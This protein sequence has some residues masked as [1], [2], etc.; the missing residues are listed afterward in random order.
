[1]PR[2]CTIC[3]HPKRK[4]IDRALANGEALRVI[5]ARYGT[6]PQTL[7]RHKRK[8]VAPALE[9]A[10]Q[11]EQAASVEMVLDVR[12]ELRGLIERTR[13]I[14]DKPD[15]QKL[16]VAALR[17]MRANLDL[18]ARLNGELGPSVQVN[19]EVHPVFVEFRDAVL[20]VI[21]T[22]PGG[23]EALDTELLRLGAGE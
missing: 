21:E 14:L 17:E 16:E 18:M 3:G 11:A 6:S 23:R 15:T 2:V 7:T 20:R 5:A 22:L 13:Q 12:A 10:R 1:M 19:V 9:E 4:A 8:C